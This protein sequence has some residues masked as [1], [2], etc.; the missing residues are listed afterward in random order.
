M[1]QCYV[2]SSIS[3][4]CKAIVPRQALQHSQTIVC[5]QQVLQTIL[6]ADDQQRQSTESAGL[7]KTFYEWVRL[8]VELKKVAFTVKGQE[9]QLKQLMPNRKAIS[10]N[11]PATDHA[12]QPA[13]VCPST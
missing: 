4:I 2:G 9:P 12:Q 7:L 8:Q 6:Q 3:R 5:C 10:P 13:T 11:Q 1:P